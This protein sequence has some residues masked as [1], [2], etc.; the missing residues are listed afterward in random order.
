LKKKIGQ[1]YNGLS[2]DLKRE[3]VMNRLLKGK[4]P[5]EINLAEN[6]SVTVQMI[7]QD[8]SD[9]EIASDTELRFD[10]YTAIVEVERFALKGEPFVIH[11]F[12]GDFDKSDSKSW[13]SS[14]ARLGSIFNFV[15]RSERG[16]GVACENCVQQEEEN[17]VITGSIS[18]TQAIIQGLQD[19]LLEKD[20][21]TLIAKDGIPNFL[22]NYF[23]W[24]V[25][26]VDGTDVN[27]EHI[28]SL[29]VSV[30][31]RNGKILA[32]RD[33]YDPPEYGDYEMVWNATEDKPSG[34]TKED[35]ISAVRN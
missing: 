22:N 15:A 11:F 30:L 24:R 8:F 20:V 23:E 10:D 3:P 21:K 4:V 26:L 27:R 25:T 1:L 34:A 35:A 19:P 5:Q 28:G 9:V 29:K 31:R 18:L 33:N 16:D 13:E 7:S 14:R 6:Q 32:A 12:L 2:E 17:T